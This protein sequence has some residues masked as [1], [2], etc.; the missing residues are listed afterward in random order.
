MWAYWNRKLSRVFIVFY[1]FF[2]ASP[3]ALLLLWCNGNLNRREIYSKTFVDVVVDV[4]KF[5]LKIRIV[6]F[7][8]D[9]SQLFMQ[10]GKMS[11]ARVRKKERGKDDEIKRRNESKNWDWNL[12]LLSCWCFF[13]HC[14]WFFLAENSKR[15]IKNILENSAN[16]DSL[17]SFMLS[18]GSVSL[19]FGA[20]AAALDLF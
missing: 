11:S 20:T 17:H 5:L 13:L 1:F 15:T 7:P 16:E 4:V 8:S 18:I 9:P 6:C 14:C 10:K 19:I 2:A 12:L 3:V